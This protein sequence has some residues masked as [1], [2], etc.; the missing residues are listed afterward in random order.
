MKKF[1]FAVAIMA[2]LAA[3][4]AFAQ[5]INNAYGNTVA[6]TYA[7]GRAASYFFNEDGTF[8]GIAPGGTTMRGRW[9]IEGEE[10]CL[11]PPG[12]QAPT[13]THLEADKNVGDT[14]TQTGSDGSQ[15]TVAITAGRPG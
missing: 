9:A 8:T 14:W 15:I 4:P 13:C 11:I 5:T 6:V 10:L 1:A 3:G 2:A 12:G 7:D